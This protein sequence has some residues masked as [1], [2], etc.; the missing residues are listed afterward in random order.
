MKNEFYVYELQYPDSTPFC[1]GKGKGSR[2]DKHF[3]NSNNQNA[4]KQNII[5][6][7][8]RN[9]D[10]P[11]SVIKESNLSE[12]AAFEVEKSLIDYYGRRDIGTDI[13][14]N[15][16]DGGEGVSGRICSEKTKKKI[17]KGNT[18]KVRSDEFIQM[19]KSNYLKRKTEIIESVSKSRLGSK[20]S[21]ETKKKMSDSAK[22][23]PKSEKHKQNISN[24]RKGKKLSEEHKQ[25][26]SDSKKGTTA[27]NK[28]QTG[29]QSKS[30]KK[31]IQIDKVTGEEIACWGSSMDVKRELNITSSSILKV[32][33]GDLNLLVDSNG[34]L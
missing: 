12:E 26:I 1:V 15:M 29:F 28:G 6:K 9:G 19:C 27:W 21:D 11:I 23:K 24:A 25:K 5:N 17:S 32:C 34:I 20:L 8:R 10:E 33:Y 4:L 31:V 16:T 18:G 13:L 22:G 7:I 14:S 2:I 3:M 30:S